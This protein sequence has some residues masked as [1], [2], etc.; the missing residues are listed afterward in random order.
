M[1][2]KWSPILSMSTVEDFL[3]MHYPE[4]QFLEMESKVP[5]CEALLPQ[6]SARY[7]FMKGLRDKLH[8]E[9]KLHHHSNP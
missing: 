5:F 3:E 7:L 9:K 2:Q 8:P 1:A 6:I 4:A